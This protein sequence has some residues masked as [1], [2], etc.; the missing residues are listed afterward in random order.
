LFV[1]RS[2]EGHESYHSEGARKASDL[3]Y[4]FEFSRFLGRSEKIVLSH[5]LKKSEWQIL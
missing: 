2:F 3:E 4:L 1:R 5:F